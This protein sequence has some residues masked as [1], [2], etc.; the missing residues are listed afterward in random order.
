MEFGLTPEQERLKGLGRELARDFAKRAA[1]HDRDRS[2]P[3]ENFAALREAGIYGLVVPKEYGGLGGGMLEWVALA[4]EIAQGCASTALAFNMH[5]NA[6]GGILDRAAIGKA[7]KKR[8]AELAVAGGKLMCTSASEMGSSSLLPN[9]FVFSVEAR[10]VPGGYRLYG[11]KFFASMW[12]ASDLSYLFVHPQA[13][14]NEHQ[15]LA[16]LVDAKQKDIS[17]TDIWDTIG[18]RATRSNQVNYDGAFVPDE[19]VLYEIDDFGRGFIIEEST[20][21]FGGFCAVYLGLGLGIVNWAKEY[22]CGRI[23]QG[24]GQPMAYHPNV[25]HRVGEMVT[26][27]EQARLMV[28]RAAWEHKIKGPGLETFHWFVRAKLA[29]GN[30]MQRIINS[31]AVACGL[32]AMFRSHPLE[33]MMRDGTTAAIMPP[34]SDAAAMAVGALSMGLDPDQVPSL[35]PAGER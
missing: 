31:A 14:P 32:H 10:K 1:Q 28:Y 3:V 5:I 26:D 33:R 11:R 17:V 7:T 22:L 34:N 12:E 16:V 21:A 25:C 30:A 2:S 23:P 18:M 24:Y 20:W 19:M 9:A 35:R 6:T 15:A 13:H 4:E 8:V 29:V 27:I